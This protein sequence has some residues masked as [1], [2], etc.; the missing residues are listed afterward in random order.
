MNT[1]R[2]GSHGPDT[3]NWQ[4]VLGLKVDGWFGKDTDAAT[5]AWQTAH[6]LTV[7]GVVGKATWGSIA[8]SPTIPP[9]WPRPTLR[10]SARAVFFRVNAPLEA[11]IAWMYADIRGYVTT[12]LGNLADPIDRAIGLPFKHGNGSLASRADIEAEWHIVKDDPDAARLGASH[13]FKTT[14]LRLSLA[15]I[16]QLVTERLNANVTFLR[17]RFPNFDGFC[18]DA[19]LGLNCWAWAGGPGLYA[20]KFE[21]ALLRG[22]FV[23]ASEEVR[24]NDATNPGLTPRNK[25][26]KALFLN[27]ARVVRE[28]LDPDVLLYK[29]A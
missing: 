4:A 8:I 15:D 17:H 3:A 23:T 5:R 24:L 10:A 2:L 9:V 6:R 1:I 25:I 19:Q 16:E 20:P 13:T 18:A 11:V 28:G 22:D 14:F 27:A 7:D 12:G 29:V 26:N 21:A